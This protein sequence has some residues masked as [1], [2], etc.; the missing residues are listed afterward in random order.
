M[1]AFLTSRPFSGIKQAKYELLLETN[2]DWIKQA[3]R[4]EVEEYL[5]RVQ[6]RMEARGMELMDQS[7]V[8]MGCTEELKA[9]D[10]MEYVNRLEQAQRKAQEIAW[11]EAMQI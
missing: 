7:M 8:E 5:D 4:Q 10:W 9:R 6:K 2:P 11:N 1:A 3:T